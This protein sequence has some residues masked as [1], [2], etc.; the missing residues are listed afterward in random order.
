[1]EKE[2]L[3]NIFAEKNEF[4]KNVDND[5]KTMEFFLEDFND[6]L[7]NKESYE[8]FNE[9]LTNLYKNNGN[10]KKDII[11][12]SVIEKKFKKFLKK[13]EDNKDK[14]IDEYL[15]RVIDNIIIEIF[16]D[17]DD[18]DVVDLCKLICK[19]LILEDNKKIYYIIRDN[20]KIKK[21]YEDYINILENFEK[22]N[23]SD[24]NHINTTLKTFSF[25]NVL[26]LYETLINREKNIENIKEKKQNL[27]KDIENKNISFID[28]DILN[29]KQEFMNLIYNEGI[30]SR[31]NKHKYMSQV[32]TEEAIKDNKIT[33]KKERNKRKKEKK[34]RKR[35]NNF[36][37]NKESDESEGEDKI[38]NLEEEFSIL[39]FGLKVKNESEF[40]KSLEK[41]ISLSKNS[42][43]KKTSNSKN[44]YLSK[45]REEESSNK[46]N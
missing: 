11:I 1:M 15:Q 29:K 34:K 7:K 20:E 16:E 12:G 23:T 42:Q 18:S 22:N 17:F 5:Y 44:K 46:K 43:N 9:H 40:F 8:H 36:M 13:I 28:I 2:A 35:Q 10:L 45:K 32:I 6:L 24:K 26:I 27:K 19:F 14:S 30:L 4:K 25:I 39:N 33:N 38:G 37:E 3:M 21:F 31:I 41:N